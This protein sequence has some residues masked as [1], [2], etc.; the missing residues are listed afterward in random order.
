MVNKCNVTVNISISLACINSGDDLFRQKRN[1]IAF[2][3]HD[4]FMFHIAWRSHNVMLYLL[5]QLHPRPDVSAPGWDDNFLDINYHFT[6]EH[7][8][9]CLL[10]F[11]CIERH[12][13]SYSNKKKK[14]SSDHTK[15]QWYLSLIMCLHIIKPIQLG[16]NNCYCYNYCYMF[17]CNYSKKCYLNSRGK[18]FFLLSNHHFFLILFDFL[19]FR[20]NCDFSVK[21]M[22]SKNSSQRVLNLHSISWEIVFHAQC[23]Y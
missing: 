5:S 18:L 20:I 2:V 9:I 21:S 19:S 22:V 10:C 12:F 6:S 16:G 13:V 23:F 17:Q 7:F 4:L 15:R 11:T 3:L 1:L 8:Y 14:R